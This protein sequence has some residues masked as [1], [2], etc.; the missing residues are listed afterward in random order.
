MVSFPSA[1]Q[2]HQKTPIRKKWKISL[3]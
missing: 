1:R 3:T 2:K